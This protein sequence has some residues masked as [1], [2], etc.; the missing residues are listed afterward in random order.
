MQ[1][2]VVLL[3]ITGLTYVSTAESFEDGLDEEKILNQEDSVKYTGK[4]IISLEV[5][6]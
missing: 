1:L 3:T 6:S 4:N 5:Q 2:L